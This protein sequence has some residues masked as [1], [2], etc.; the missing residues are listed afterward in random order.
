L[1]DRGLVQHCWLT[2]STGHHGH[3]EFYASGRWS[4]CQKRESALC[5]LDVDPDE[6]NH[7]REF[8]GFTLETSTIA[9]SLASISIGDTGERAFLKADGVN[10]RS[11]P[12]GEIIDELDLGDE[13]EILGI[14]GDPNWR[15]VRIAG[16]EGYVAARYLRPPQNDQVEALLRTVRDQWLRFEKGR[17]SEKNDP[18]CQ[19]VGEMWRAIGL[20]YD[21][22]SVDEDGKDV[23]WSAAFISFMVRNSGPR[24]AAFLFSQRHSEFVHD[25]IQ[26]RLLNRLDRPFWGYRLTERKPALG[27][28]IARNRAGNNFSYD[29]AERHADYIS[30]SDVVVEIRE[31]SIRVI[32]GNVGNTVSVSSTNASGDNSQE[33]ELDSNGFLKPG[34]KGIAVLKNRAAE[35]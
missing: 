25:A 33:Y 6:I 28:I 21:G 7:E 16:R 12:N 32:G 24:Y 22:R 9:P 5:G 35:V 13:A 11:E 27:D 19:Y 23:P 18:Y 1:L 34:Q 15:Q 30:H 17:G 31:Q 10:F 3:Q 8:G 2:M 20:D 26:A 14:A 4:L 29:H